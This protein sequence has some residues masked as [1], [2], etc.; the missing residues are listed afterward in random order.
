MKVTDMITQDD[1][2]DISSTSPHYFC[3]KWIGATNRYSGG[4]GGEGLI[5]FLPLKRGRG[6]P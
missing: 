6:R 4:G 2:L 3:K 5:N 1:L